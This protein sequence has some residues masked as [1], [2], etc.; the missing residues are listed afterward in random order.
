MYKPLAFFGLLGTVSLILGIIPFIRFAILFA[1][2]SGGQHIQ[3]LLFGSVFLGIALFSYALMVIAE[4]Q[5]TNRILAED[6]LERLKE[7]QYARH[8]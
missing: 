2:D 4:L 1:L 6:E 3:S 5:R 8:E 7:L